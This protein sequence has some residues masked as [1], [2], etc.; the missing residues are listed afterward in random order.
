MASDAG[1]EQTGNK[2]SIAGRDRAQSGLG[3]ALHLAGAHDHR[4][5]HRA[6]GTQCDIEANVDRGGR[7][8][9]VAARQAVQSQGRRAGGGGIAGLCQRQRARNPSGQI[10]RG[11]GQAHHLQRYLV[12][13]GIE[14]LRRAPIAGHFGIAQRA[15]ERD[16]GEV[17][18]GRIAGDHRRP[19]QFGGTAIIVATAADLPT[20][21]R[22]GAG[23]GEVEGLTAVA[24]QGKAR[25]ARTAVHLQRARGLF[26]HQ[27][28]PFQSGQ[29]ERGI[30]IGPA[31]RQQHA[32]R[33]PEPVNRDR[34]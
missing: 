25:G 9:D 30:D 23:E 26:H 18:A 17:P 29:I 24:G 22:D 21:G 33:E 14:P 20:V 12:E 11:I 5:H 28:A 27:I 4:A 6:T 8:G 1:I 32:R 16:G 31:G 2:V 13:S 10:E 7:G 15:G 3:A 19:G 34:R